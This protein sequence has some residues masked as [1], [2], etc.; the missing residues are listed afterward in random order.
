MVGGGGGGGGSRNRRRLTTSVR[1]S[2]TSNL[3]RRR[4]LDKDGGGG[5][6][7]GGGSRLKRLMRR[8]RGREWGG[9]TNKVKTERKKRRRR[10]WRMSGVEGMD[11]TRDGQRR[12]VGAGG[13]RSS[14]LKTLGAPL[15]LPTPY[16]NTLQPPRTQS[17]ELLFIRGWRWRRRP[18]G[19]RLRGLTAAS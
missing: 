2:P 19:G 10:S 3:M 6:G 15:L 16:R 13:G 8:E 14:M 1:V 18:C 17:K 9:V 4:G 11:V 5:G 12:D 7:A